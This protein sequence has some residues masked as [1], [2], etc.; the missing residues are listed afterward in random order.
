M[1]LIGN[2]GVSLFNRSSVI[3]HGGT[4][5]EGGYDDLNPETG[6]STPRTTFT[7]QA[8]G[9]LG[10]G[11][12]DGPI[13]SSLAFRSGVTDRYV[14]AMTGTREVF[15]GGSRW[16]PSVGVDF[17]TGPGVDE[18]TIPDDFFA[19]RWSEQ[20]NRYEGLVLLRGASMCSTR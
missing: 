2:G 6:E 1:R 14:L 11:N 3:H 20:N 10:V 8:N 17:E 13:L 18:D 9:R 4:G 5:G 19:M 7:R 15:S 16:E 12:V